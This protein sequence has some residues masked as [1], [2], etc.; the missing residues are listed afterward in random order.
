MEPSIFHAFPSLK[1]HIPFY[2]LGDFPTLVRA[3][4]E[5]AQN[6]GIGELWVKRDDLSG[7]YGWC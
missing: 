4:N 6:L 5:I 2:N 3:E 1:H 7:R